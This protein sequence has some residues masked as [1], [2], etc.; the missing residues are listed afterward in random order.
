MPRNAWSP[1]EDE[2]LRSLIKES[3]RPISWQDIQYKL[4]TFGIKKTLRQAKIRWLNH[5]CPGVVKKE[6]EESETLQLFDL[7]LKNENKWKLI[8]SLIEGRSDNCIKNH[9][10]SVIRKCLR[11]AIRLCGE[12]LTPCSAMI[13]QI[14][15]RVLADFFVSNFTVTEGEEERQYKVIDFIKKYAFVEYNDIVYKKSGEEEIE[16]AKQCIDFLFTMNDNYTGKRQ[17]PKRIRK[18]TGPTMPSLKLNGNKLEQGKFVTFSVDRGTDRDVKE[19]IDSIYDLAGKMKELSEKSGLSITEAKN[20]LTSHLETLF[21][22]VTDTIAVINKQDNVFT[23]ERMSVSNIFK[24]K[25]SI[26]ELFNVPATEGNDIEKLLK[27]GA[28]HIEGPGQSFKELSVLRRSNTSFGLEDD[29]TKNEKHK[30]RTKN[31]LKGLGLVQRTP[32]G[33]RNSDPQLLN[34]NIT[35]NNFPILDNTKANFNMFH[36]LSGKY[37]LPSPTKPRQDDQLYKVKT[38]TYGKTKQMRKQR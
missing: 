15:P 22:S 20:E 38:Y 16:L 21:K 26:N 31:G 5:L 32:R 19:S 23:D 7:Y 30:K 10:Y 1:E 3:K 34:I 13:R 29:F 9:F 28:S 27:D 2:K 36:G 4:S 8:A 11:T 14:K 35:N 25:F 18:E 37:D 17:F 12:K 6:W 24:S 33:Y